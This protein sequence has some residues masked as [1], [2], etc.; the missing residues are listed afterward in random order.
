MG[1]MTAMDLAG[2]EV[3][4]EQQ[5]S[6]HFSSNCYPPIPQQMIPTAIAAIDACWEED[7]DLMIPLPDG[8]SFRGQTEV[9][10][11]NVVESYR[12]DA[13]LVDDYEDEEE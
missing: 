3:S 5:L 7:Y 8:V 9:S 11:R 6:I 12:L 4:L 2:S 13:W 1:M 10:A